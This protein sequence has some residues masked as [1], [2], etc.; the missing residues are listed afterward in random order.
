MCPEGRSAGGA[1][2]GVVG[3]P[4]H[5]CWPALIDRTTDQT[6]EAVAQAVSKPDLR[7]KVLPARIFDEPLKPWKADL[8]AV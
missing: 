2:L 5:E 7:A 8:F 3:T 1:S 4:V 6:A